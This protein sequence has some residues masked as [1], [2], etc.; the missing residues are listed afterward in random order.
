[1]KVQ[2]IFT[3][4]YIICSIPKKVDE[5]TAAGI[6]NATLFALQT[7]LNNLTPDSA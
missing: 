6:Q 2:T 3:K 7:W 5:L 1:M 4:T